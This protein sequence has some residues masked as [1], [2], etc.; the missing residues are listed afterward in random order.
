MLLE[1]HITAANTDNDSS[2]SVL[3]PIVELTLA[4][5]LHLV[6]CVEDGGTKVSTSMQPNQA[7]FELSPLRKY[8]NSNSIT[9][10]D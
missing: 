5:N 6:E 8:F 9:C 10:K 7:I 1:F 4:E 2:T 3:R